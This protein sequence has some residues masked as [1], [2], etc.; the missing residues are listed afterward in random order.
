MN[1]NE[2]INFYIINDNRYLKSMGLDKFNFFINENNM[3]FKKIEGDKFSTKTSIVTDIKI[4][5]K[6]QAVLKDIMNSSYSKKYDVRE[7]EK[8]FDKYS[9]VFKKM[10]HKA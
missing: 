6:I 3:F 9:Q 8:L 5:N 4:H 7:L 10:S 1:N 2:N